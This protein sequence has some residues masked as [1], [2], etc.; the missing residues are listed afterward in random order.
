MRN[1]GSTSSRSTSCCTWLEDVPL[2]DQHGITSS[3]PCQVP[4]TRKEDPAFGRLPFQA[5]PIS[6]RVFPGAILFALAVSYPMNL[7]YLHR[8]PSILSARKRCADTLSG[9][10]GNNGDLLPAPSAG[11]VGKIPDNHGVSRPFDKKFPAI[12]GSTCSRTDG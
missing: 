7:R 6:S 2:A 5:V 1:S 4:V 11:V 3:P 10:F 9:D 12:A 8:V